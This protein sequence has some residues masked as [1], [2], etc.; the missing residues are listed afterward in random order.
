MVTSEN[1]LSKCIRSI[2]NGE[3]QYPY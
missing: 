2:I 1:C 3:S